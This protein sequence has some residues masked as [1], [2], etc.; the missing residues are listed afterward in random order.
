MCCWQRN[1]CGAAWCPSTV[2]GVHCV[3]VHASWAC[4]RPRAVRPQAAATVVGE[5]L[6]RRAHQAAVDGVHWE[7]KR[8]QRYHGKIAALLTAMKAGG[9]PLV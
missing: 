2:Q 7:R 6:A 9:L 3:V 8:G 4:R 1:A 5:L